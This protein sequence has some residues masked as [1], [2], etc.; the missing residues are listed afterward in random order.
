M[1]DADVKVPGLG[2]TKK[3]WVIVGITAAG[4]FVAYRWWQSRSGA[5]TAAAATTAVVDPNNPGTGNV[6]ATAQNAPA[7]TDSTLSV[8]VSAPPFTDNASWTQAAVNYLSGI[9]YDP[10]TVAQALGLFLG[11]QPLTSDQQNIVR[12]AEGIEGL[13]PVG[14]PYPI[15]S[16]Q[17][18]VPT[19]PIYYAPPPPVAIPPRLE[20]PP[21]LPTH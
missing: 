14:G 12:A 13:P 2:Q 17:G 18:N 15:L 6:A 4:G 16:S 7:S 3:T 21:R 8:G 20:V 5:S 10:S 11:R 19:S 1:A 9:G